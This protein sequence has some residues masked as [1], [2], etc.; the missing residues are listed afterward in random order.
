MMNYE[1]P[2]KNNQVLKVMDSARESAEAAHRRRLKYGRLLV[3][4]ALALIL[5]S[6]WAILD[7]YPNGIEMKWRVPAFLVLAGCVGVIV[8]LIG[9]WRSHRQSNRAFWEV[10]ICAVVL[11]ERRIPKGEWSTSPFV[12][13]RETDVYLEKITN[14]RW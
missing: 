8:S 9:L 6:V 10:V 13:S 12:F 14:Q 5:M 4:S 11:M 2:L 3:M 1:H 7:F